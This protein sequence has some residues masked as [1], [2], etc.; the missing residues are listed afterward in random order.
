MHASYL[1]SN[2]AY[3][4]TSS[5]SLRLAWVAS[6]IAP[7][8]H[9][10]YHRQPIWLKFGVLFL[11]NTYTQVKIPPRPQMAE[12]MRTWHNFEG[13]SR[14]HQFKG[15]TLLIAQPESIE[16]CLRAS[17]SLQTLHP[18]TDQISTIM[19]ATSS[20]ASSRLSGME[21]GRSRRGPNHT[22]QYHWT[23]VISF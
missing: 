12:K 23:Y 11:A 5:F 2:L 13:N 1:L 14:Q 7:E 17:R 4:Q 18:K 6:T 8:I 19:T 22:L 9:F 20:L 21:R 16:R 15:G 3:C 10:P